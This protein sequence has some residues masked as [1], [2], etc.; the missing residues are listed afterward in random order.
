MKSF[1]IRGFVNSILVGLIH[2]EQVH[3]QV[4]KQV[5]LNVS[6][7]FC[8]SSYS[9]R[10]NTITL[11][12]PST[13]SLIDF[14]SCVAIDTLSLIKVSLFTFDSLLLSTTGIDVS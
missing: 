12:A 11:F 10:L 1:S 6:F 5:H 2:V 13:Q 8:L 14:D 4:P 9:L 3:K 7:P